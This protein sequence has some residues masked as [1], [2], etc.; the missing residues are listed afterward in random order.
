[1][2]KPIIRIL[3]S[4]LLVAV[5]AVGGTLAYLVASDSPLLNTFA[6]MQ[7]DT[8][9]EEP[10]KG[11]AEQK[12]PKV[13]NTGTADVYVRA[14]AYVVMVD[15]DGNEYVDPILASKVSP[16]Y[17]IGDTHKWEK[18]SDGYYYYKGKL[19]PEATTEELFSGVTVNDMPTDKSFRVYVYQESVLAETNT[20]YKTA[21][22]IASVFANA[23]QLVE[24]G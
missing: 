3:L 20:D 16:Q 4:V 2:K 6:L 22:E 12:A 21:S 10:N 15:E 23:P 13:K 1:M 8:E 5:V 11:T 17:N 24:N 19:T 9:I 14:Y 7:I 18:G